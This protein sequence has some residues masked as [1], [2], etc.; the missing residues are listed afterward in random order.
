MN[1]LNLY[2]FS[3]TL[4]YILFNILLISFFIIFINLIE[5]SRVLDQE[6]QNIKNYLFLI[7]Y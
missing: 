2:L 4:K 5:I 1:K 3:N 7:I 6:N